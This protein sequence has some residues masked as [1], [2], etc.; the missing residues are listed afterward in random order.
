MPVTV[1]PRTIRHAEIYGMPEPRIIGV[2]AGCGEDITDTEDY[3]E[4]GYEDDVLLHDDMMCVYKYYRKNVL[5][6]R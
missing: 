5:I 4:D 2:C 6:R 3:F 1:T